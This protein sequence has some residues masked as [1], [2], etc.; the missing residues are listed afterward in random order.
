MYRIVC[1]SYKNYMTDFL[2]DNTDSYRYKIMLPFRLAFDALLYKEE[3]NKNS[4]D[5]QKLEHFVYLA[6]KNIDK[7]PNIKSFLWSLESRGIYGVN[8]GVLSEEEFNEQIKIINMFL[9]LAYW[10]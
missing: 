2:P 8:Y 10:Y 4:S 6:K 5:Y 1:E 3:K 9:K 7:Y